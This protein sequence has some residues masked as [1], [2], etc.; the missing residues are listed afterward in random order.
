[1]SGTEATNED[2]FVCNDLIC[3]MLV[4]K[5]KAFCFD[6]S[7][8]DDKEFVAASSDVLPT[9]K[10]DMYARPPP[11]TVSGGCLRPR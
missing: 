5:K 4:V 2:R 7:D 10:R 9:K 11:P 6:G 8:A 3:A 1:M